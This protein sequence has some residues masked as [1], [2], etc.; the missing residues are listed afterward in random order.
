MNLK[1]LSLLFLILIGIVLIIN[2]MDSKKGRS[3]FTSEL[4]S[5]DT[6][7]VTRVYIQQKA[8]QSIELQKK[9][10][11]W[12]V[13]QNGKEYHANSHLINSILIELSHLKADRKAAN[14][15]S[16]WGK[17]QVSD[18]TGTR[19]HV[20]SNHNTLA[21]LYLGKFSFKQAPQQ[22]YQNP[23]Q[24]QG[25]MISYVRLAE[26][27]EVYATNSFLAMTLN[28]QMNQF[29]DL[30]MTQ[31]KASDIQS[32][33][34]NYP[35]DSSFI[36]EKHNQ[37]WQINGLSADS[38]SVARYL[39]SISKVNGQDLSLEEAETN[40]TLY[41]INIKANNRTQSIDIKAYQSNGTLFFS[42]SENNG[43]FFKDDKN[44][45]FDKFFIS[46]QS[47]IN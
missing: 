41:S 31:I 13:L 3:S 16:K 47:L 25:S 19:I 7:Q 6:T 46:Q 33:S 5:F 11:Q 17:Y 20:K 9:N 32:I 24:P 39:S 38:A 8:E 30:Q 35:G 21:D 45:L 29:F 37:N 18:S 34:F 28:N 26:E 2:Y 23:N 40:K 42:S 14:D 12:T 43:I 15:K 1:T 10:Y 27:K 4:T 22:N 44:K 36:L